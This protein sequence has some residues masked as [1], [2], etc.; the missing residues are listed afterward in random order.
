MVE[1]FFLSF[2]TGILNVKNNLLFDGRVTYCL[3]VK[4]NNVSPIFQLLFCRGNEHDHQ[5]S[6]ELD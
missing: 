4:N 5:H 3:N 6:R 2:F 1:T